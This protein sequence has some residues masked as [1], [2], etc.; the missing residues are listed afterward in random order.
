MS[1]YCLTHTLQGVDFIDLEDIPMLAED[2]SSK[3]PK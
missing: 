1:G 2:I 3:E